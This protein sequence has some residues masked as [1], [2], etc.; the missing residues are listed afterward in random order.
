M[1]ELDSP[2]RLSSRFKRL[3]KGLRIWSDKL[4]NLASS[5]NAGNEAI[6]VFDTLEEFKDLD[7]VESNGRDLFKDTSSKFFIFHT[8]I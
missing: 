7:V 5:I 1:H 8:S 6:L 2:K 3:R 4:T